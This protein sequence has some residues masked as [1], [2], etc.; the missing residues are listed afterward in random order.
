MVDSPD[1]DKRLKERQKKI[2]E[3]YKSESEEGAGRVWEGN[4]EKKR[5]P[6]GEM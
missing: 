6:D 2:D 5:E 4:D 1:A 3:F